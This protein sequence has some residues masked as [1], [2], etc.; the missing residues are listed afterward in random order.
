MKICS[1]SHTFT[2]TFET[3]K[4]GI[5]L[6]G[7]LEIASV[8]NNTLEKT[9][10]IGDTLVAINGSRVGNASLEDVQERL[11]KVPRPVKVTF[12]RRS[13]CFVVSASPTFTI[14]FET[15][16]LGILLNETLAIASVMNS[17]HEKT[18]Q[19]GDKLVAINGSRVEK[20]SLEEIQKRLMKVRRPVKVTFSRT[21]VAIDDDSQ[22]DKSIAAVVDLPQDDSP[23]VARLPTVQTTQ[24]S[25]SSTS[26]HT[27][28]SMRTRRRKRYEALG[29]RS[30]NDSPTGAPS[31]TG[32]DE[33][34]VGPSRAQG[35]PNANRRSSSSN[36]RPLSSNYRWLDYDDILRDEARLEDEVDPDDDDYV[37]SHESD[38]GRYF[39]D[40]DLD[41]SDSSMT[42]E[43]LDI[44]RRKTRSTSRSVRAQQRRRSRNRAIKI[45]QHSRAQPT[46]VSTRQLTRAQ[47]GGYGESDSDGYV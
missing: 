41:L 40:D 47:P 37:P 35:I 18:L 24:A 36:G 29:R 7:I 42:E 2:I 11:M 44:P 13:T 14:T 6:N 17:T 21:I 10:K 15:K 34:L 45:E 23:P 20:A 31:G 22:G 27:V 33:P 46:R 4:L 12:S 19:I 28:E 43:E 32:V 9:L 38:S 25:S 3:K 39:D 5:L 26:T 16:K 8:M 1:S 30:S